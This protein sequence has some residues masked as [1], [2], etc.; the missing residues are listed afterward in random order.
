MSRHDNSAEYETQGEQPL[1]CGYCGH[2]WTG[3]VTVHSRPCVTGA[4]CPAC[5]KT[6]EPLRQRPGEDDKTDDAAAGVG[7]EPAGDVIKTLSE[8]DVIRVPQYEGALQVGHIGTLNGG[9]N[10]FVGL[11]FVENPT[12]TLKTLVVNRTS[13]RVYLTAGRTDKGEVVTIETVRA[14]E[15]DR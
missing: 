8:G 4:T 3:T 1:R 2:E 5:G 9:A 13:G 15:G 11:E 14:G 6:Q 7:G 12:N 10:A